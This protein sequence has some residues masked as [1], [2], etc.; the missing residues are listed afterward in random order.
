MIKLSEYKNEDAIDILADLIVPASEIFSDPKLKLMLQTKRKRAEIAKVA[1]KAHKKEV[2]E[3]L[4]ILD[5]VPVEKFEANPIEL[6]SKFLELLSDNDL[7]SF[8][9]SAGQMKDSEYSSPAMDDTQETN[10]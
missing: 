6:L 4:S 1:L 10:E 8:F 3:I 9:S 7:I 5:N 2:I